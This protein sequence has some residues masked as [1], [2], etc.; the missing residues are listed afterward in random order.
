MSVLLKRKKVTNVN[1]KNFFACP[2]SYIPKS[3]GESVLYLTLHFFT[4]E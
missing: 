4:M 2:F 3:K 1:D